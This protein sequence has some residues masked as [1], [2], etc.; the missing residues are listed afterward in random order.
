MSNKIKIRTMN[1]D[2]A[3]AGNEES[4]KVELK[5]GQD[6]NK[7]NISRPETTNSGA[8]SVAGP[9]KLKDDE[10]SELR[11]LIKKISKTTD[12]ETSEKKETEEKIK[13]V[14]T[15]IT[16]EKTEN[17]QREQHSP[18]NNKEKGV[19]NKT[20]D[21]KT[22]ELKNLIDKV[23]KT[24]EKEEAKKDKESFW[25]NISENLK[26][27]KS[28]ELQ[29]INEPEKKDQ[30]ITESLKDIKSAEKEHSDSGILTK[31]KSP[32]IKEEKNK[33]EI[34]KSFHGN[35]Y[36]SPE[37]R[38]IFGKQERYS[39]VSK[40]IR[41]K[42]KSDDMEN[43]KNVGGVKDGQK[44]ISEDEKY[45]KLKNR[46]IKKYNIKLFLLPW[47][48][49]ILVSVVLII[50]TG[51]IYYVL[52]KK[53]TPPPVE[54][55]IIVAG[56][57]IE[58]FAKIKSEVEF[59]KDNIVKIGF[60][61]NKINKE[62][63]LNAGAEELKVV[64]KHNGNIILPRDAMESIKINTNDFPDEFWETITKS[65][66]I[67]ALKAKKDSFKFAIAVESNNITSLLKTMRTW[68][69]ESVDKKKVF[70]VFEP[71]FTDSEIEESL[72][73]PFKSANYKQVYIRYINLPDQNTSFDYFANG[74]TLIITASKENVFRMID[75]LSDDNNYNY[76]D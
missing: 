54:P 19:D 37:N 75:I 4:P 40:R 20:V 30:Q 2:L 15:K 34:K 6:K 18:K 45:K 71:I 62:F 48:K 7:I 33:K 38:L 63:R 22:K 43:L 47:K 14:A 73:Q 32:E 68:E 56:I 8:I 53:L 64:I 10:V 28:P 24:I 36:Q 65:Y 66:N 9:N 57:E 52:I 46:V 11:N 26:D 72:N 31:E 3:N 27:D 35:N 5:D 59:T 50:S 42:E 49:I 12:K 39:S 76:S 60:K 25:G 16:S 23:S 29:K 74:D 44:I 13:N 51:A 67:F 17:K 69:K 58:D 70:N 1:D 55:P 41:L 21:N 61:E